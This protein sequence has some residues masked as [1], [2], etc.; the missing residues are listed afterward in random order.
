MVSTPISEP[1]ARLL[2]SR[3]SFGTFPMGYT[4]RILAASDYLPQG[5]DIQFLWATERGLAGLLG[6]KNERIIP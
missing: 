5:Y 3:H 1:F 2:F 6:M 4:W